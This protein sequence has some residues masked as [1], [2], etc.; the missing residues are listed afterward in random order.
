MDSRWNAEDLGITASTLLINAHENCNGEEWM[1]YED[2]DIANNSVGFNLFGM[3]PNLS[4]QQVISYL[5]HL[6]AWNGSLTT[7]NAECTH[8]E[9]PDCELEIVIVNE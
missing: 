1:E 2:M 3:D 4:D 8:R 7:V 6:Q 9:D 5:C